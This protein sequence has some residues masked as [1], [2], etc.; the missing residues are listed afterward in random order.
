MLE[1]IVVPLDGS[2]T[3]EM[4]LPYVTE[5]AAKCGSE[6]TLIRV[7]PPETLTFK[8]ARAYTENV[9]T[10]IRADLVNWGAVEQA[11]VEITVPMGVPTNEIL[12]FVNERECNLVAIASRGVSNQEQWPLGETAERILRGSNCPVLLIRKR[13]DAQSIERKRFFRRIM[14]PLD[15][16]KWG[17][18]ALPLVEAFAGALKAEV[19]LF[20]TTRMRPPAERRDALKA[21]FENLA[22][23]LKKKG[24]KATTV[25]TE[26]APADMIL[27]YA[28]L[29][30]IDLI[31]MSTHGR[32]GINRWVFGSVT[33]KVLHSGDTAVLVVRPG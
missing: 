7:S 19:V 9:A 11:G 25:L 20:H 13:A 22:A 31:A 27:D 12:R 5:I 28:Q 15:G 33:E 4:V 29:N 26:G 17:E 1:Q 6:V 14:I 32:S 8:E 18:A 3:A 21:Y 23:G 2:A 30:G 16:S 24:I 10:G